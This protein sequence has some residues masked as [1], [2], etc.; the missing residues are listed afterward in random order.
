MLGRTKSLYISLFCTLIPTPLIMCSLYVFWQRGLI[1]NHFQTFFRHRLMVYDVGLF[2]NST[3]IIKKKSFKYVWYNPN[4]YF[5]YSFCWVVWGV[6][7]LLFSVQILIHEQKI[8][9]QLKFY[10]SQNCYFS[11]LF[12][13][14]PS[15]HL[16]MFS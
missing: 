10:S 11:F 6:N 4:P 13:L 16:D 15:F 2:K 5:F 1:N 12:L 8:E 7:S 9:L 3:N 14:P